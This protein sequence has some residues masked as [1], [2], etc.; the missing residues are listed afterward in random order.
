MWV[1]FGT[2]GM[3]AVGQSRQLH[4]L[5]SHSTKTGLVSLEKVDIDEVMCSEDEENG[6][7]TNGTCVY[8]QDKASFL[9]FHHCT[10]YRCDKRKKSM[11]KVFSNLRL[12]KVAVS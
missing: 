2:S 10:L 1:G 9:T 4:K 8:F 6:I 11:S 7:K 5:K 3:Y 12:L